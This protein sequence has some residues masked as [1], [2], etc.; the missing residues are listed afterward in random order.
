MRP[1]PFTY[2]FKGDA[3]DAISSTFARRWLGGVFSATAGQLNPQSAV[4]IG[5]VRGPQLPSEE[6]PSFAIWFGPRPRLKGTTDS[7]PVFFARLNDSGSAF[8]PQR[9]L[10]HFARNRWRPSVVRPERQR[11]RRLDAQGERP[12]KIIAAFFLERSSDDGKT[13]SRESPIFPAE[14]AL[15]VVAACE[16][17]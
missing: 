4:A 12:A 14:L 1:A 7:M 2:L 17:C 16:R 11:V 13:F 6:T 15:V 5:T 3:K 8:E 10:V 9:N